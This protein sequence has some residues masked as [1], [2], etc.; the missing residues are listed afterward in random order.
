MYQIKV[1]IFGVL[2]YVGILCAWTLALM[3]EA[4][5]GEN[6]FIQP[7]EVSVTYKKYHESSRHPLFTNSQL[8]EGVNITVNTDI[9]GVFFWDN[10]VHSNTDDSQYRHIGWNFKLGVRPLS[11]LTLQYEHHSQHLLDTA[12]PHMKFPVEDSVGFTINIFQ[13]RKRGST[14]LGL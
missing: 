1:F 13:Q 9:L 10:L 5:A 2:I 8:K 3:S 7:D 11:W 6:W 4:Q 12:Y 14:L